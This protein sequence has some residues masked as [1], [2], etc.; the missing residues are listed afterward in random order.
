MRQDSILSASHFFPSIKAVR[1]TFS[2]MR[3]GPLKSFNASP[4][5]ADGGFLR[6][7]AVFKYTTL[8]M[9]LEIFIRFLV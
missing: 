9:P 2:V 5:E 1:L 7:P 8:G 6:S 3:C 4:R